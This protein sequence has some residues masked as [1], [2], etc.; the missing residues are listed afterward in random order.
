MFRR[1]RRRILR[2]AV[3]S[4]CH[5]VA[6][7]GFRLLGER[8]LDL[9]PYGLLLAADEGA[10]RGDD[11]LVSFQIPGCRRVFD[12]EAQVARVI[13]GWRPSDPGYALGLRFT[14]IALEDRI[15]L[16]QRLRGTP[17]P[18]PQRRPRFL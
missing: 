6:T 11:V 14:S 10:T 3:R 8:V 5:A 13:E 7:E 17:P 12:A 2:R 9:S 4:E 15:F 1:R 16:T 18:V